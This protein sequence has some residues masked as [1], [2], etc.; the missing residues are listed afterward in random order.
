VSQR[1]VRK[2]CDNCK[3]PAQLTDGQIQR[4]KSN[5]IDPAVIMQAGKCAKCG[6]TG[7]RGRMAITDVLIVNEKI[8]SLLTEANISIGELKKFGDKKGKTTLIDDGLAKVY[9]G[10]T[11]LDEV[12]RVTSNLG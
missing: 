7:Y 9:A 2:L 8:K 11:T 5:G 3:E 10:L 4:F 1:L 12:R 6:Q